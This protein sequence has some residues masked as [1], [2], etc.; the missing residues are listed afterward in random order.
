M[1]TTKERMSPIKCKSENGKSYDVIEIVAY[2]ETLSLSGDIGRVKGM[3]EFVLPNG[4]GVNLN[5]NGSFE[6]VYTGEILRRVS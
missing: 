3:S 5:D 4:G 6:I 1:T 2:I